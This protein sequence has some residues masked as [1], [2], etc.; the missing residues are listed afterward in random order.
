MVFWAF[1]SAFKLLIPKS[2]SKVTQ[3]QIDVYA[4]R[5]LLIKS[6][7]AW[8]WGTAVEHCVFY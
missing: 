4:G 7:L 5:V 2:Y 3:D 8:L 1:Y 6:K